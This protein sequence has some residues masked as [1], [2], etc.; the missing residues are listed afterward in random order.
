MVGLAC[1]ASISHGQLANLFSTSGDESVFTGSAQVDPIPNP[2]SGT[3]WGVM[4]SS[5]LDGDAIR[6]WD[7]DG[8]RAELTYE[9]PAASYFELNFDGLIESTFVGDSQTLLRLG[10]V[11]N[12]YGAFSQS[13]I[14]LRLRETGGDG[15]VMIRLVSGFNNV[16]V[17]VD[18]RFS[19]SILANAAAAGS[20]DYD[21]GGVTGTLAPKEYAVIVNGSLAGSYTMFT[22]TPDA[23]NLGGFSFLTGTGAAGTVAPIQ[24]DNITVV[25]EPSVYALIAGLLGLGIVM[26][27]R[28]RR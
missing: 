9:S 26:I 11:G 4:S 25:P 18:T 13:S 14:E 2:L 10:P 24:L 15:E 17:G 7:T 1:S 19:V 6:I 22:P 28:R 21:K 23:D 27:R 20:V 16:S 3:G 12:N 5:G 8:T